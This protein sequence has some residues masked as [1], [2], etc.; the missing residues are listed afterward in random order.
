[1][2]EA[3]RTE[4][5]SQNEALK[6]SKVALGRALADWERANEPDK[7]AKARGVDIALDLLKYE[8]EK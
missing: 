7:A 1:M 6:R 8:V 3:T 2:L 4:L 5:K